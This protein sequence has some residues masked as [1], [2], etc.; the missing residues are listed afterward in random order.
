M[1]E[2]LSARLN[3]VFV[4]LRSKGRLSEDDINVALREVRIALLEA[5][6]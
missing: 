1:F 6:V 3:G 2:S 5:D 4:K